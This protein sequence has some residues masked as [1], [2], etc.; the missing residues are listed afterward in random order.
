[1]TP[2]LAAWDF[3]YTAAAL[4]ACG[5]SE[6]IR[7]S[8][9]HGPSA[10]PYILCAG[11]VPVVLSAR[12]LRIDTPPHPALEFSRVLHCCGRHVAASS[13]PSSSSSSSSSGS[14]K[15]SATHGSGSAMHGN[16]YMRAVIMDG[17]GVHALR[18]IAVGLGS[19]EAFV[20]DAFLYAVIGMGRAFLP[21]LSRIANTGSSNELASSSHVRPPENLPGTTTPSDN[22]ST[23]SSSPSS[24]SHSSWSSLWKKDGS[25][26]LLLVAPP[27]AV[28]IQQL[29]IDAVHAEIT[30][31]ASAFLFLSL[32]RAVLHLPRL[33]AESVGHVDSRALA[34]SVARHYQGQAVKQAGWVVGSL[35]LLG[36]PATGIRR[37][38]G[39]FGGLL[40][41]ALGPAPR[42]GNG[43]LPTQSPSSSASASAYTRGGRAGRVAVAS[44]HLLAQTATS[45]LTS[46]ETAA[47]SVGRNIGRM[48]MDEHHQ[49]LGQER[50]VAWQ[51]QQESLGRHLLHGAQGFGMGLLAGIAGLADQPIR[52]SISDQASVSGVLAGFGRGVVGLVTKP[53]EGTF[54]LVEST[55]RG[56]ATLFPT[57]RPRAVHG[58]AVLASPQARLG[59][60]HG[61]LSLWLAML[62][63]PW[64]SSATTCPAHATLVNATLVA[65][66]PAL[67]NVLL[68]WDCSGRVVLTARRG[69]GEVYELLAM[70][71]R[72][73]VTWEENTMPTTATMMATLQRS[74]L[75]IHVQATRA[76]ATAGTAVR[77]ALTLAVKKVAR[78]HENGGDDASVDGRNS[79]QQQPRG[80]EGDA[81]D[82][83]VVKLTVALG[84]RRVLQGEL[85]THNAARLLRSLS[86]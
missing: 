46:V 3:K 41:A 42:H 19:V 39:A 63:S 61:L 13:S 5:M 75:A 78:K 22:V 24:S 82:S 77:G 34:E 71:V 18:E 65:E 48:T 60:R 40:E 84:D 10:N 14:S 70:H 68:W 80:G 8:V 16:L 6:Y 30:A 73:A 58:A 29:H 15:A 69:D 38:F 35:G 27:R 74:G 79:K 53:L 72:D 66:T 57:D 81:S 47:K 9:R 76:H 1:M 43:T 50:R 21:A 23:T 62:S 25:L 37:V 2:T 44:Q 7:L 11:V 54:G 32:D 20:E 33:D 17:F 12:E 28:S 45:L 4:S 31:H 67:H 85:T 86:G 51:S 49:R 52:A 59:D 64:L 83:E 36:S 55:S 26:P 56:I